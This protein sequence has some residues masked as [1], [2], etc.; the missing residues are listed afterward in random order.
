MLGTCRSNF[1]VAKSNSLKSLCI[2]FLFLLVNLIQTGQRSAFADNHSWNT[3]AGNWSNTG[4]WSPAQLPISTDTVTLG[5]LAIAENAFVS[6]D[7]ND[8]VAG[9][10]IT[11]GI[12][13]RTDGNTLLVNGDTVV[14]GQNQVDIVVWSSRLIVDFSGNSDDY[15]TNNL[16]LTDDGEVDLRDGG[17]LEVDNVFSVSSTSAL[18]G[19]GVVDFEGSETRVFELDGF[20]QAGV[21]G[22]TLNQN[23]TGRLD[24]DGLV[25]NGSLH[26]A[27]SKIDNSAHAWLTV[28]GD[29]LADSFS[30]TML[31]GSDNIL[32]MNLSNGWTADSS[33]EITLIGSTGELAVITGSSL[34]M[35]GEM[36]VYDGRIDSEVSFNASANVTMRG[37]A[38]LRLNGTTTFAGASVVQDNIN[39]TP[40]PLITQNG[41]LAVTSSTTLGI[42]SGIFNWD[43]SLGNTITTV[44]PGADFVINASAIDTVGGYDGQTN[45]GVGGSVVVNTPGLW[46]HDG[47]IVL[48][49]GTFEGS[50]RVANRSTIEGSGKLSTEGIDNLGTVE[51][52]GGGLLTIGPTQGEAGGPGV[53]LIVDGIDA[54]V[55]GVVSRDFDLDGSMEDGVLLATEGDLRVTGFAGNFV[56]N[57]TLNIAFGNKFEMSTGGLHNA[58]TV[59]LTGAGEYHGDLRQAGLLVVSL[60]GL[61]NSQINSDDGRFSSPG[62]NTLNA[63]LQL[64]GNLFIEEGALFEG[65]GQL[66]TMPGSTLGIEHSAAVGVPIENFGRLEMGAVSGAASVTGFTNDL[67]GTL[68]IDLAS[69][70][71]NPGPDHDQLRVLNLA[72]LDGNLDVSLLGGFMPM[73]GDEFIV[74]HSIGGIA[75]TFAT[76]DLPVLGGS[77][78]WDVLYTPNDVILA[79]VAIPEPT[80]LTLATFG[81]LGVSYRR[82][83]RA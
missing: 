10:T 71:G 43:G 39:G 67:V 77:N 59:T 53:P 38:E 50:A 64:Q 62:T 46:F 13:L 40:V 41:D 79:V 16:T 2:L 51:S 5:D 49:N 22:M 56:F 76:H 57:G 31:I 7:I 52:T 44:S 47:L 54:I 11:D 14:S 66:I 61:V 32:N 63:D 80:T 37:T 30:G 6:L 81:L 72:N 48:D 24:L 29:Q 18:R 33:S 27:T 15:D 70:G 78:G 26:I 21:D 1:I 34:N 23:G 8:T 74:L 19:D 68:A 35:N 65:T 12:A 36:L 3:G 69:A 75:G 83:K 20:L 9:V 73:L 25:G 82:R 42:P 60:G 17:I 58:G 28:N 4:N 55:P 45:V